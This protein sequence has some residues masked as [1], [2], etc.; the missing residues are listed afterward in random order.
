MQKQQP[1]DKD[2]Y[3]KRKK[4]GRILKLNK[5]RKIKLWSFKG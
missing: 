1:F 5:R 4:I 2:N 3:N